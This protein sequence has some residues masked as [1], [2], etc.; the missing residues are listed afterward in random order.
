LKN[1]FNYYIILTVAAQYVICCKL[2]S[3]NE[4]YSLNLITTYQFPC[5]DSF[6]C[7]V[8][9]EV[10]LKYSAH[11]PLISKPVVGANGSGMQAHQLPFQ[12]DRN[13]FFDSKDKYHLSKIAKYFTSLLGH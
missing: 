9:K 11:A 2:H 10:A 8:V 1:F 12:G 13:A 5:W 6:Y 3:F 7:L 4:L